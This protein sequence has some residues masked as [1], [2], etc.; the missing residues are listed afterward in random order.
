ME[1]VRPEADKLVL[2]LLG[3][4]DLKRGDVVENR[5]GVCRIGPPLAKQLSEFGPQLRNA[6]A[7]HAEQLSRSLLGKADVP[8][9]ADPRRHQVATTGRRNI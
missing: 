8:T 9:P 3:T 5:E 2:D 7:P 6:L 4:T 1:P